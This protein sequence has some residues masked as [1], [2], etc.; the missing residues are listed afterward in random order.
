M[1]GTT[2]REYRVSRHGVLALSIRSIRLFLGTGTLTLALAGCASQPMGAASPDGSAPQPATRSTLQPTDLVVTPARPESH[3][4]AQ[5]RLPGADSRF[6]VYLTG[7][8]FWSN[9]PAASAA[10]ARPVIHS[11]AG[12]TGTYDDPLT[13]AVGHSIRGSVQ[14]LDYPA[15]TRFYFATLHKYA[16]V[17]DVCGDGPTPQDEACHIGHDGFPWLDIYVGGQRASQSA[18]YSCASKITSVMDVIAGPPPGL[19]V[20]VGPLTE[21]GCQTFGP[22]NSAAYQ[23]LASVD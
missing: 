13:I 14:V 7:Y 9:T 20:Q 5:P 23:R 10:I 2:G 8:S 1:L 6:K 12:G 17:E 19:P 18:A 16:I 22:T 11:H 4:T 21:G 3:I 15:G